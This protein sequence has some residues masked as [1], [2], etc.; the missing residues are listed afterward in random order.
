MAKLIDEAKL[1]IH[2]LV[3][4]AKHKELYT[5]SWVDPVLVNP[6]P[7]QPSLAKLQKELDALSRRFIESLSEEQQQSRWNYLNMEREATMFSDDDI[8]EAKQRFLLSL[9][10]SQLLMHH[11][12]EALRIA[13]EKEK[14]RQAMI[15]GLV[16]SD[17][18]IPEGYSKRIVRMEKNPNSD[19]SFNR[20]LTELMTYTYSYRE[21]E[22]YLPVAMPG[23]SEQHWWLMPAQVICNDPSLVPTP[24]ALAELLVRR[25][26]EKAL[27][28]LQSIDGWFRKNVA[29]S[30]QCPTGVVYGF[31][32]EETDNTLVVK[33]V[34]RMAKAKDEYGDIRME[35]SIDGLVVDERDYKATKQK[36]WLLG[37]KARAE[38]ALNSEEQELMVNTPVLSTIVHFC[39]AKAQEAVKELF[40]IDP[41]LFKGADREIG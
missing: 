17:F 30:T 41:R 1:V 3:D 4:E 19:H 20:M 15:R 25:L 35:R 22:E 24:D 16:E 32:S 14:N 13:F 9:S 12:L 37:L 39:D 10:E 26:E 23:Y 40:G 38:L 28:P 11:E 2:K 29:R 31:K 18:P 21:G 27:L 8:S 33:I 7:D 5:P 36:L 34:S 6:I